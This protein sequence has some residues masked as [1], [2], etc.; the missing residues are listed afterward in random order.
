[1]PKLEELYLAS[2]NLSQLAGYEGL[3]A[4]RRL[5]LRKN[6]IEKIEEE[7]VPELPA[8]ESLNLRSN[9]IPDIENAVRLFTH[10]GNLKD[11]N[12]INNDVELKYSSLNVLVADFL[13]KNPKLK[14][15]C[16]V[17]I[18]DAH[19]LESVYLAKYKWTKDEEKRIADEKAAKL[20]AAAEGAE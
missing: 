17:D 1:M 11:L 10:F 8:L 19:R 5:H 2:N 4:L 20:A 6:K 12:L 18:T 16:K 14:R 3:P 15:F 7:G 13:A 9:K